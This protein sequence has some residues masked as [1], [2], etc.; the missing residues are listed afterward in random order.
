ESN[1]TIRPDAF[2][3]TTS[4]LP[5]PMG[6]P[7]AMI[8][9]GVATAWRLRAIEATQPVTKVRR[10]IRCDM[11]ANDLLAAAR[12]AAFPDV[13]AANPQGCRAPAFRE[14]CLT[15][16]RCVNACRAG[17][18]QARSYGLALRRDRLLKQMILHV[19]RQVAPYPNNS[20]A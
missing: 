14:A 16:P 5:R 20:L 17:K 13:A 10:R 18:P 2:S 3:C 19:L 11:V 7:S 4:S 1:A 6:V 9:G 12:P 8:A 15:G